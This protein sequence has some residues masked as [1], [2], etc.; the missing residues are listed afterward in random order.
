M[1]HESDGSKALSTIEHNETNMGQKEPNQI[2]NDQKG[3]SLTGD[4][5]P[6]SSSPNEGAALICSRGQATR[7]GMAIVW[8]RSCR[9]NAGK[10]F[11]LKLSLTECARWWLTW[12]HYDEV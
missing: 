12:R 1:R 10:E 7:R 8:L 4:S 5:N 6:S 9:V 3:P 2:H 11:G